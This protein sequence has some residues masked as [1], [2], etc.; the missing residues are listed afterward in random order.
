MDWRGL[1][2]GTTGQNMTDRDVSNL[3]LFGTD[4]TRLFRKQVTC[5]AVL[6]KDLPNK[7]DPDHKQGLSQTE[8]DNLTAAISKAADVTV[9][10]VCNGVE[11]LAAPHI[12]DGMISSMLVG[13]YEGTEL[14]IGLAVIPQGARILEMGAGSG[15]VGAV[16]ARNCNP[17]SVLSIEANPDLIASINAL[18]LHNGL[19]DIISV[20][21]K[22]VLTD[23]DAPSEIEFFVRGN[24][25]GSS[26]IDSGRRTRAVT[27]PVLRYDALCEAYPHDTIMMDI[28]G[29]ELTFLRHAD[30]SKINLFI[31]EMH[32][33]VYGREGL[34]ECRSLLQRAGLT[35]CEAHS[36]R[37]V[38]VYQRL[39]E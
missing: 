1:W 11:V 29:G 34:R 22:V 20:M 33:D 5:R 36:R 30:L 15:L 3:T 4:R 35:F 39:N 28:E 19:S 14:S 37:G 21:N 24:F 8:D 10:A 23:P 27:V 25:L 16:L 18:Y 38:H 7:A 26:L 17:K 6:P 13:R 9:V 12:G 32:R 2:T 31:A